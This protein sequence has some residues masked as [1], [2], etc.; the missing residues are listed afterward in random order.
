MPGKKFD[1]KIAEE[2]KIGRAARLDDSPPIGMLPDGTIAAYP[3]GEVPEPEDKIVYGDARDDEPVVGE[4]ED[5]ED[6]VD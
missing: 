3:P 5:G 1:E 6:L 4:F 2:E